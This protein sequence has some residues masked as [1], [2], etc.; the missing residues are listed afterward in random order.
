MV[1]L[2]FLP[3]FALQIGYKMCE[4]VLVGE[5]EKVLLY[6][7][8]VQKAEYLGIVVYIS[9]EGITRNESIKQEMN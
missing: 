5:I 7:F 1:N 2:Y 3:V 8:K 9:D 6:A 4:K